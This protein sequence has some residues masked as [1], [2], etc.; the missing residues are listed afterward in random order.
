MKEINIT[1]DM[2]LK[3]LNCLNVNKS[4]GPD[5]I[6]PRIP[7]EV[8]HKLWMHF[9]ALCI[10][11]NESIRHQIPADCKKAHITVVYKK[12]SKTNISNYRHKFNMCHYVK[13]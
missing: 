2:V 5:G 6:N 3:K 10:I 4:A 12:G 13:F 8:K 7:Q 1:A 11:C 9:I